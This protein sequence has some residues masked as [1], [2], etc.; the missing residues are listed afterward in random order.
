[1]ISGTASAFTF[2]ESTHVYSQGS[3]TLPGCTRVI[4]HSGLTSYENIKSDILERKSQLGRA[5]H[6]AAHY[7]DEADLDPRY[8]SDE[9]RGYLESWITWRR[10]MKF[11]A[12]AIEFQQIGAVN[13]MPFGM[14]LDRYG[15]VAK[16]PAIVEIKISAQIQD[17]HGIQLAGYAAGYRGPDMALSSPIARFALRDRYVVQ[18]KPDGSMPRMKQ[19]EDRKDFEVFTWA[20][21]LTHWKLQHNRPL[22]EE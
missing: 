8:V 9:V 13:G 14:K 18:L 1:M 10:H 2:N 16:R 15:L 20:L 11:E 7:H 17:W 19:F 12:L 5:V 6:D 22:T 3:K 21:G 4:D